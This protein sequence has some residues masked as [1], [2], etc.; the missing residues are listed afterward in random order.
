MIPEHLAVVAGLWDL[1]WSS[2][3]LWL[4]SLYG[5]ATEPNQYAQAVARARYRPPAPGDVIESLIDR[6]ELEA[7]GLLLADAAFA[8]ACQGGA[9]EQ[10]EARLAAA[11]LVQLHR[12]E[13]EL[14]SLRLRARRRGVGLELALR[15]SPAP[16]RWRHAMTELARLRVIVEGEDVGRTPIATTVQAS[17]LP[18]F[19]VW[20][21]PDTPTAMACAWMSGRTAAP[22]WAAALRPTASD[23]PGQHLLEALD[24]LCAAPGRRWSAAQA[25]AFACGLA[26]CIGSSVGAVE[27]SGAGFLAVLGDLAEPGCP[28]FAVEPGGSG[29]PL[30]IAPRF[31]APV[32]HG[33]AVPRIAFVPEH[34][35][36]R[37]SDGVRLDAGMLLSVGGDR[38]RR[39]R[40]LRAWVRDVPLR[41]S[42][43]NP[44]PASPTLLV[45]RDAA[46]ASLADQRLTS[47]H[48]PPGFGT[49]SV[50]RALAHRERALGRGVVEV[51][52]PDRGGSIARGAVPGGRM[53]VHAYDT[54]DA[55]ARAEVDEWVREY[56][57]S[58][59]QA[60]VEASSYPG[61]VQ[62]E[63]GPLSGADAELLAVK[64]LGWLDVQAESDEV[65]D[66]LAWL[67]G[68]CPLIFWDLLR[69]VAQRVEETTGSPRGIVRRDDV[70]AA[71]ESPELTRRGAALVERGGARVAVEVLGLLGA[72]SE[73]TAVST[74][75][76]IAEMSGYAAAAKA[77]CTA[78]VAASCVAG[79]VTQR[80]GRS[81]LASNGC[82]ALAARAFNVS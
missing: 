24:G 58:G 64:A 32:P 33:T 56:L 27:A 18:P 19:P 77:E 79:I 73:Q 34:A 67:P 7:V 57:S 48:A 30:W 10:F 31:D 37:R 65:V 62:V 38:D 61:A 74:D 69:E 43:P 14:A 15:P 52:T 2:P 6:G 40:L 76:L 12:F 9:L 78:Q 13:R 60:V 5:E 22:T 55:I 50:V 72:T 29:V 82:A 75:G 54:F 80:S 26:E 68:G 8:R 71:W 39:A 41:L 17:A 35:A 1:R 70:D 46:L 23:S 28:T 59:G 53:F 36:G 20:S 47:V 42:V 4:E 45:G 49:T 66:L 16:M 21:S 3:E 44:V 11:T 51:L 81:W 63:L 25:Q